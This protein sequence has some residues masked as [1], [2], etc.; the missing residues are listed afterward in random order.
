[1]KWNDITNAVAAGGAAAGIWFAAFFG[2]W[3]PVLTALAFAMTLDY[4]TGW[5]V[6]YEKKSPKTENGGLSSKVGFDGLKR[7]MLI[8][9]FV[10]L[11]AGLDYASGT[12]FF[13]TA[14]ATYYLANEALSIIEN[15][16]LLGM[17]F[18][19]RLMDALEAMRNE[20]DTGSSDD[21]K[22]E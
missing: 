17:K 19:K 7:K 4:I 9:V 15:A 20:Q 21:T 18:P 6:G 11:G 5:L 10:L 16:K 3:N 22:E 14:I 8:V 13:K 1:M 12:A 2:P